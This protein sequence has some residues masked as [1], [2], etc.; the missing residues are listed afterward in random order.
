MILL[1]Q[2]NSS[3]KHYF[4]EYKNVTSCSNKFLKIVSK[5][6]IQKNITIIDIVNYYLKDFELLDYDVEEENK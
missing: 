3:K 1:K 4:F 6:F 2:F 5:N